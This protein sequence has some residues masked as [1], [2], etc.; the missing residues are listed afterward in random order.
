MLR[1]DFCLYRDQR[2]SSNLFHWHLFKNTI[3][4]NTAGGFEIMLPYVW[5]Y[6]ENYTH[7]VVQENNTWEFNKN[8]AFIV[9]GHYAQVNL[10]GNTFQKNVCKGTILNYHSFV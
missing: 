6:N 7:S 2:N 4:R 3:D 10:S 1:Y 5:S 9:D 8:F